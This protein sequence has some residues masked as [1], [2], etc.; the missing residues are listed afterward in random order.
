MSSFS[1]RYSNSFDMNAFICF[2]AV[3]SDE[4]YAQ[5]RACCIFKGPGFEDIEYIIDQRFN[6][7][8]MMRY[9]STRGN[10]TGFTA[11]SIEMAKQFTSDPHDAILRAFEKKILCTDNLH[12]GEQVSFS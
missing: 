2:F 12:F 11:F 5:F 10:W 6:M 3:F 7:K 8:L 9:N 1:D 4:D